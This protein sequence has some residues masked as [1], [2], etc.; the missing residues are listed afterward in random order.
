MPPRVVA[1]LPTYNRPEMA[2]RSVHLFLEQDYGGPSHLLAFDDGERPVETCELCRAQVELVRRPRTNLPA[3]RNAMMEHVGDREAFYFMWDDDD[4][5]GPQRVSRQVDVLVYHPACLLRPTLYYN[6]ITN[7]LRTSRWISDATVA[8]TWA[9]WD[10]VRFDERVD[11][12]SGYRFVN[13]P[14]VVAIPGELDYMV[15]V[16]AGQR[17]SPPAFGPPDFYEA[18]VP[19]SWAE[20]RLVLR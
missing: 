14:E 7:D 6:Q 16:H 13:R 12:G 5:H 19:A 4:Y 10:R 18:P 9:Y 1:L 15:V 3:K 11:P 17:H 2:H 20:E 8:F